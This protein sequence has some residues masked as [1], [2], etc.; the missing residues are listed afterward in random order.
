MSDTSNDNSEKQKGFHIDKKGFHCKA[1][2]VFR[3]DAKDNIIAKKQKQ[4]KKIIKLRQIPPLINV[5]LNLAVMADIIHPMIFL[6]TKTY[7]SRVVLKYAIQVGVN[8]RLHQK[9]LKKDWKNARPI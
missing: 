5:I 7:C 8:H 9:N 2:P 4:Q 6:K 3:V 1:F